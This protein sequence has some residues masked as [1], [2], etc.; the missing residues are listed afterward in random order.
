MGTSFFEPSVAF[1]YGA[2]R[3]S[4]TAETIDCIQ[5]WIS[6]DAGAL[7]YFLVR[8]IIPKPIIVELGAWKGRSTAWLA[9]AV[10]DRGEGKVYSVDTWQGTRGHPGELQLLER[11]GPDDLFREFHTNLQRVGLDIFVETIRG[12]TSTVAATWPSRQ[13]EIGLL[14]IDADHRYAAVRA[15]FEQW[16]RFVS[17]GSYI[18]FDDVPGWAGPTKLVL[19]I[20]CERDERFLLVGKSDNQA[21]LE[22]I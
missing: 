22:R 8:Q 2:E 11:Y 1:Q 18:V 20:L 16:S 15:D 17:R 5:G 21:I 3:I 10:R 6:R 12:E 14:L 4:A 7:L 9:S 13:K 19:E